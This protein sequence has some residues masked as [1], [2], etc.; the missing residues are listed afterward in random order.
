MLLIRFTT[1][2]V[3][4][5]NAVLVTSIFAFSTLMQPIEATTTLSRSLSDTVD[6]SDAL[7]TTLS[8]SLSDSVDVSDAVAATLVQLSSS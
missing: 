7:S 5:V 4:I 2:W 8:K 1:F 6:V 3:S